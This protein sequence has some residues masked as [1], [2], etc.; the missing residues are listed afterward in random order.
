M[1]GTYKSTISSHLVCFIVGKLYSWNTIV[2]ALRSAHISSS[3]FIYDRLVDLM[4][5]F[6]YMSVGR[7]TAASH[8]CSITY[9]AFNLIT[10][11]AKCAEYT[12]RITFWKIHPISSIFCQFHGRKRTF[13]HVWWM[14]S[15][16]FISVLSC[17]FVSHFYPFSSNN[18]S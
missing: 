2:C 16:I 14:F 13:S 18:R 11:L 4:L 3:C 9:T 17:G 12:Q 7:S 10:M 8:K 15:F 5:A 6:D 1:R